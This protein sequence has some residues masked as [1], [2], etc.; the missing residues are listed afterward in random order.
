MTF[1]PILE[2]KAVT[3]IH[4]TEVSCAES[5]SV[6]KQILFWNIKW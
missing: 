3:K 1:S 5:K 4:T 6:M 2:A